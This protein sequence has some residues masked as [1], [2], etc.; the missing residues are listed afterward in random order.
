M[1]VVRIEDSFEIQ[2]NWGWKEIGFNQRHLFLCVFVFMEEIKEF[3]MLLETIQERV[4]MA[5]GKNC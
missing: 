3:L 5:R 2:S 1:E 4:Y